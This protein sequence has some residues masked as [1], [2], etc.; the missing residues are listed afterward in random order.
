MP[1][2]NASLATLLDELRPLIVAARARGEHPRF[3]LLGQ[4]AYDAVAAC[5]ATDRERWMPMIVLGLE[6]VRADDPDAAP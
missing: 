3:V 2:E 6:I 4:A 5:K 1:V